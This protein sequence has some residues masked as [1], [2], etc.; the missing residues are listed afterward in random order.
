M[1]KKHV[2]KYRCNKC[3]RIVLRDRRRCWLKSFCETTGKNARLYRVSESHSALPPERAVASI[4]ETAKQ[5][6][7]LLIP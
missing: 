4:L 3:R 6:P 1:D 2:W 7:G 5:R